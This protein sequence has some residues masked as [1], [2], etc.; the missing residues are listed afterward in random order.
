MS[1]ITYHVHDD[2]GFQKVISTIRLRF[3][4]G[5]RRLYDR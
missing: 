4:H 5:Q 1:C 2:W 3:K